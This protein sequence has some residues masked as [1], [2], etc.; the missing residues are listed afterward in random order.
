LRQYNTSGCVTFTQPGDY[1]V[2]CPTVFNAHHS[3]A[4]YSPHTSGLVAESS[5]RKKN[6]EQEPNTYLLPPS[7]M[8]NVCHV[9]PEELTMNLL[10]IDGRLCFCHSRGLLLFPRR[11]ESS[12]VITHG[13]PS[14]TKA[15]GESTPRLEPKGSGMT[16]LRG[17]D[18]QRDKRPGYTRPLFFISVVENST[19]WFSELSPQQSVLPGGCPP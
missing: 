17:D 16:F 8:H 18:D 10:S 15:F 11:R 3:N 12:R 7:M 13:S 9:C 4:K 2:P 5:C 1:M 6:M 19:D 14:P